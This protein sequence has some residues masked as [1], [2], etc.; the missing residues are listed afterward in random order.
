MPL[1]T[2]LPQFSQSSDSQTLPPDA[3][4]SCSTPKPHTISILV[5]YPMVAHNAS[6]EALFILQRTAL[7]EA[8]LFP[9]YFA[10][11]K[12]GTKGPFCEWN[13]ASQWQVSQKR[14]LTFL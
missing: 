1:Y 2:L 8:S 10:A 12:E 11:I 9:E 13:S 3:L 6:L 5:T 4:I 14:V 7:S